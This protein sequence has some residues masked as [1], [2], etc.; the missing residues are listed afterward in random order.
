MSGWG[1]SDED[2]ESIGFGWEE[3]RKGKPCPHSAAS[4]L[5]VGIG[6]SG[7]SVNVGDGRDPPR[8]GS[9][10]DSQVENLCYCFYPSSR[11]HSSV[12]FQSSRF[13]R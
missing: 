2:F 10:T 4:L 7:V 6:L 3:R 5:S 12:A 13:S 11:S 8:L 1:R 9:Q